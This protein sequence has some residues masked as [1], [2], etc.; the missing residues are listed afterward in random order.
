MEWW[1]GLALG[2]LL[3]ASLSLTDVVQTTGL[4]GPPP[5]TPAPPVCTVAARETLV[6]IEIHGAIPTPLPA[7]GLM[8]ATERF[9]GTAL[10]SDVAF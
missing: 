9:D 5:G 10:A 1:R 2:P 7:R 3:G 4:Q 8:L 6:V